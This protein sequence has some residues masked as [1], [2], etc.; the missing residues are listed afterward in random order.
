MD[1]QPNPVA[2]TGRVVV[3]IT[4]NGLVVDRQEV[5]NLVTQ[6]GDQYYAERAAGIANPPPQVTGMKVGTSST[7]A[8]KTGAG[9]ALVAYISGSQQDIQATYPQSTLS[10][11]SRQ[12]TWRAVWP[13]GKATSAVIREVVLTNETPLA[14]TAGTAAN[15]IAR[16][17]FAS[18][19]I[20]TIDD[21]MTVA[22]FHN[23]LGA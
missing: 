16:V 10:G 13:P 20:K 22:W 6:V 3:E 4:R 23:F 18:P 14:D 2:I 12:I 1:I 17:V 21:A 5:N 19:L 11:S 9:A 8:A 7:A 15:T